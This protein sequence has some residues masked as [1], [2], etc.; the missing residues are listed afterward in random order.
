MSTLLGNGVIVGR[1]HF[2]QVRA[3]DAFVDFTTVRGI[4]TIGT[5]DPLVPYVPP[6]NPVPGQSFGSGDWMVGVHIQSGSY[7]G[8]SK[9]F[10]R[11]VVLV[12]SSWDGAS[13]SRIARYEAADDGTITI[14]VPSNAAGVQ[15]EQHLQPVHAVVPAVPPRR[16]G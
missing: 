3:T 12:V 11:C 1:Y 6:A 8:T 7:S 4:E 2:S 15:G 9:E 5:C 16:A 13:A 14:Q 10:A